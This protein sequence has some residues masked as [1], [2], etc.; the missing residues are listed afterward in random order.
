MKT[1]DLVDRIGLIKANLAP[2]LEALKA[3]EAELKAKGAGSY[4]GSLFDANVSESVR[5]TLDMKAVREKLS[6]QFISAHTKV[7]DVVV[8]RVTA[9]TL[10]KA[11]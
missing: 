2:Q 3:L 8:L 9:K 10:A 5:E 1:S 4:E 7:S 6:P 11:A